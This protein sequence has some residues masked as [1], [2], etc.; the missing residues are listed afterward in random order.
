LLRTNADL[1]AAMRSAGGTVE[2]LG[3]TAFDEPIWMGR[4]GGDR[5]APIV[6]TAGSHADEV[7][8]VF[9]AIDLAESLQSDHPI[10]I[11]PARDPL[12]WNGF[13]HTL[14]RADPSAPLV[15]THE[16]ARTVLE[17]HEVLHDDGDLIIADTGPC[18]FASIRPTRWTS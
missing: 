17:R 7:A 2:P 5:G 12:G 14:Q 1:A 10:Y 4:F 18:C 13:A 6:I 15:T 9:A 16:D 3:I 8:G 11:I